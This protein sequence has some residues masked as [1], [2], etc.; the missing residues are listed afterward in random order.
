[1]F[2]NLKNFLFMAIAKGQASSEAVAIKRY[3]GVGACKVIGVNPTKAEM[4]E[5]MG[6]EPNE[7]PVYFGKQVIDGKEVDYARI[8]FV[9]KTVADKCNG[10]DS[11]QMVTFFIRNQYRKGATSGKY[12]VID[13]YGRTAWG[14]EED[15]KAKKTIMYSNGPANISNNYRPTFVGEEELTNFIKVWLNIPNPANYVNGAWIMKPAT[16]AVLSECRFD[17]IK[18]FFNG[19][20]KEVTDTVMLQPDNV[21]KVLFGIRTNDEGREYQD[22][23]PEVLRSNTTDYSKLQAA[24]EERKNN[25]ALSNRTY[26]FCELK[27]YTVEPTK[28]DDPL[29]ST[30]N[31]DPWA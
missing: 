13:E 26:E 7:E 12:Q 8:S 25:G 9:I 10:I 15:V 29:A 11:T 19:N 16:E 3:I 22:I 17:N 20:F 18:N 6:F 30:D 31:S 1:M 5:L 4:K 23:Y 24:I 2:K 27:E 14:L 21:V 28:F